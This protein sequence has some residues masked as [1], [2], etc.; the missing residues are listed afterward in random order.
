MSVRG[1]TASGLGRIG[2]R[3]MC[4]LGL[5]VLVLG[6]GCATGPRGES[7][8][9]AYGE[10]CFDPSR[11]SGFT[12]LGEGFVCLDVGGDEHYLLTLT[13]ISADA[14][15]RPP[16][17]PFPT[18]ITITGSDP[19]TLFNRVCRGSGAVADYLDGDVAIHRQIVR[20][21]R[22]ADNEQALQLV[23]ARTATPGT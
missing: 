17:R 9:V 14:E 22:V 12:P 21:E 13:R 11:I 6:L 8:G 20:I 1:A 15:V 19:A 10:A 2:R 3:S 4:A 23:K 16:S 18:G 5:I 7:G